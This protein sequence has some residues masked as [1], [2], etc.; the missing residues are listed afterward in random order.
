MHIEGR[1]RTSSEARV[2]NVVQVVLDGLPGAATPGLLSRITSS[3]VR[4]LRERV[5][6]R[7]DSMQNVQPCTRDEYTN[8][9]LVNRPL[10]PILRGCG[11]C[12]GEEGKGE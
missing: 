3:G 9:S 7:Y 2:L 4:A 12:R 8:N 6:V 11:V 10:P 5:T 1:E